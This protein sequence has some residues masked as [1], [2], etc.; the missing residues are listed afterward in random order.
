[1]GL[2]FLLGFLLNH[3]IEM[4]I[5]KFVDISA[6]LAHRRRRQQSSKVCLP[7]SY[8]YKVRIP[9]STTPVVI[10]RISRRQDRF[11]KLPLYMQKA[12]KPIFINRLESVA[13]KGRVF[14]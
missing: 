7:Y 10:F 5:Y 1:M 8:S 2:P 9:L 13:D 6:T 12:G 14:V 11:T 3:R 4:K